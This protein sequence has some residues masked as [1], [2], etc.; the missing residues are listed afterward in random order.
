MMKDYRPINLRLPSEAAKLPTQLT[1]TEEF[2]EVTYQ[3]PRT[4]QR[5]QSMHIFNVFIL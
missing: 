1:A 5:T 4:F 2:T 3:F